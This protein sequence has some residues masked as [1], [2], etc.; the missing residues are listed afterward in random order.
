MRVIIIVVLLATSGVASAYPQFQP[1][2]DITCTGCHI[3][4][5]GAGLLNENGHNV[6][7]SLAW[8]QWNNEFFYGKVPTPDWLQLGGDF[9]GAAGVFVKDEVAPGAFPMQLDVQAR[10]AKGA[11]SAYVVT[12]FRPYNASASPLHVIWPREHYLMWQQKPDE[13][14]GFYVR[15]G[16]MMPTFGLR[17]AEHV[18]YTQLRGGRPLFHE[19]Y[20][21][22]ASWVTVPFEVH[23][24]GFIHDPYGDPAELGDGASLYAEARI[25]THAAVGTS[26]KLTIT[27]EETVRYTGLTGKVYLEGADITLLAEGQ[28]VHRDVKA[29]NDDLNQLVGYVM[30]SKPLPKNLQLDVGIGHFTQDTRVKGLFR[31]CIDANLHWYMSTHVELLLTT[32]LE[33][34]DGG[35]SGY[36]LTQLHYRL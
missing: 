18:V 4:P 35:G 14:Y 22:Q 20:A 31:D 11:F 25:G 30:A 17:L 7:D 16:H 12:G 26:G 1:S 3:S 5:D 15:A 28:L 19:V 23:A 6:L 10:A 34:V 32:R 24:S 21:L 29:A 36:A 13:N 9:R 27:D 2:S 33:L 8:K